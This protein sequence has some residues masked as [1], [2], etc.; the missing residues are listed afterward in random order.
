MMS[1]RKEGMKSRKGGLKRRLIGSFWREGK[2]QYLWQDFLNTKERMRCEPSI[3]QTL[4]PTQDQSVLQVM[5][6]I[7]VKKINLCQQMTWICREQ[8]TL[9]RPCQSNDLLN[10]TCKTSAVKT[11]PL[12]S[13]GSYIG[14]S[15]EWSTTLSL[16]GC[17]WA[18]TLSDTSKINI[19]HIIRR[20]F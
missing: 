12:C 19:I 5:M 7:N 6:L 17:K 2:G 4:T 3:Q 20:P 10:T 16:D 1:W 14:S 15:L 8:Q 9:M 13:K 11:T 18:L